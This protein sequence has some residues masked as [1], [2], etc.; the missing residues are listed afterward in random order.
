MGH[1]KTERTGDKVFYT[2]IPSRGID[3]GSTGNV[4]NRKSKLKELLKELD[5]NGECALDGGPWFE[6]YEN[7]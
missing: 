3:S 5:A 1:S 7:K 2:H 6:Q 4:G